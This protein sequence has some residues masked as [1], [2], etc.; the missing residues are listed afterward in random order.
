MTEP[1]A[2]AAA[3][4]A[5]PPAARLEPD[6]IGAAQDT[7]IGM[8]TSAPAASVGLT[9]AALAAASAYGSGP[10]I[11]LTAIPM[12][13][14]ANSYRRLNLWNANCGASFE[15]VGRAINPYLGFLT[16]WLMIMGSVVGTVSTTVVLGPSVLAVFGS[17]S[18]AVTPNLGIDTAVVLVMLVI[19]VAGIKITART[20]VGMGLAEYAILI[21]FALAGLALV[22]RHSPG[23]LPVSRGWLS[24]SGIGGHG[25]LSAGFLIAMFMYTGWDGTIYVNEEVRHRRENPGRAAMLAVALLAVIYTVAQVGL[26]GVVSPHRLQA[27]AP[28]ALVYAAAAIGGPAWAKVMALALAL[29][30]I[31]TTGCG[32]VLTAR[33][34]YG[35]A[36]HRVLPG[37][38]S[39]VSPRFATPVPASLVVGLVLLT[40]TWIYVLATSLA[41]AFNDVIAITGLLYAAFYILTALA[42]VVYYR[43]RVL[44]NPRD[45]V[46]LGALPLG[47][48]AFLGWILVRSL[49]AAPAAQLWSLA[50]IMAVG[51]ALLLS[52]R[53]VQRSA[54]FSLRRESDAFAGPEHASR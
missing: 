10:V 36:S 2:A 41:S 1:S 48:A 16:G 21:G 53:F 12:L 47:A 33:M 11:L 5:P 50:V 24:L 34:I 14:I 46:I 25:S 19:A 39:R 37:F 38:L 23:T 45:A 8:A 51:L 54:F 13:V 32:I 30:V 3:G 17:S 49:Q 52:A 29:S 42:A 40:V 22:L 43:R 15:W 9:L 20:Q 35:M 4:V 44:S 26:Q 31:A 7:V 28:S 27:H 18:A 6:A